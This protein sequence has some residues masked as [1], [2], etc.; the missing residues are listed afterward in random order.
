M[1]RAEPLVSLF[2]RRTTA[3]AVTEWAVA[4]VPLAFFLAGLVVAK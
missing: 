3:V 1:S 4:L 2:A